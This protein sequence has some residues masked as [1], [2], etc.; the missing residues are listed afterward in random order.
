MGQYLGDTIEFPAWY[1]WKLAHNGSAGSASHA[2]S[3]WLGR[4]RTQ[5]A[6]AC[7]LFGLRTAAS[8]LESWIVSS[9]GACAT[10]ASLPPHRDLRRKRGRYRRLAEL[11]VAQVE[12]DE[13]PATS[14]AGSATFVAVCC[15]IAGIMT[16]VA[17][18]AFVYRAQRWLTTTRLWLLVPQA[19]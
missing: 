4:E 16:R 9:I 7:G 5:D 14:H 15:E 8:T 3:P 13:L 19:R 17:Q 6:Q 1:S 11:S 2:N 10:T 18:D 12:F